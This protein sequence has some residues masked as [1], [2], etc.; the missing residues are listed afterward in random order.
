VTFFEPPSLGDDHGHPERMVAPGY[1]ELGDDLREGELYSPS[2]RR[3]DIEEEI[4]DPLPPNGRVA[5]GNAKRY[6]HDYGYDIQE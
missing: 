2:G 4:F 3:E 1:E 6:G 5:L